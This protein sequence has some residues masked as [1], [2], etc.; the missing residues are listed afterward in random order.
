ME[1]T[2][3]K[4]NSAPRANTRDSLE[5][6]LFRQD[7]TENHNHEGFY[8]NEYAGVQQTQIKIEDLQSQSDVT[9]FC[10]LS[11]SQLVITV[12][13]HAEILLKTGGLTLTYISVV[14]LLVVSKPGVPS[15]TRLA[16]TDE[17]PLQSVL[18]PSFFKKLTRHSS[19]KWAS[20]SDELSVLTSWSPLRNLYPTFL[21]RGVSGPKTFKNARSTGRQSRHL[22]AVLLT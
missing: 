10:L 22:T 9:R 3:L 5:S 20:A 13:A 18:S 7:S 19:A 4:F 11:Q 17:N 12:P 15:V 16:L 14:F 1:A 6:K 2:L 8:A 21:P